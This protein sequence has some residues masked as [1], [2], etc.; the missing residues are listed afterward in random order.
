LNQECRKFTQGAELRQDIF[1]TSDHLNW[2]VSSD[3]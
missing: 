1:A 2:V 3:V